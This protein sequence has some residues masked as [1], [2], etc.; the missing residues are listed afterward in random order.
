MT[1]SLGIREIS[2]QPNEQRS[3]EAAQLKVEK[4]AWHR[5]GPQKPRKLQETVKND[6]GKGVEGGREGDER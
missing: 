2:C 1:V 4:K 6:N 5:T 3:H